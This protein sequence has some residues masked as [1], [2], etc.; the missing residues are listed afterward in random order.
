MSQRKDIKTEE[1]VKVV[2]AAC[3]TELIQ[4]LTVL[5]ILHQ[6]DLKKRMNTINGY[7]AKWMI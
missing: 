6:D 1:K 5:A 4:F 3:W 2:A 7:L